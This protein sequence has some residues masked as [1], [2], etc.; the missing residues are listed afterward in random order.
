MTDASS[1]TVRRFTDDTR[2]AELL[3]LVQAVFRDL[4]IDPPS[5]VLRETIADFA[6]RLRAE[7]TFVAEAGHELIGSV[8][9]IPRGDAL[10]IGRL[11]VRP[12][13][14]RRGVATALMQA[15]LAEARATGA[16]RVTLK[17]RIALASNVALFRGLGFA[18]VSEDRHPGFSAPTSYE[19]E[20]AL[21]A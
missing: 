14:R 10:Y 2:A 15:A 17:A 6:Q 13:L 1:F 7:T 11:A 5:G 12:D 16:A 21:R 3:A 19:M 8:F 18:I 4:P 9:C 20:L